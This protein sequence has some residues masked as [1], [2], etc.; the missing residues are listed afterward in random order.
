M[1]ICLDYTTALSLN[2]GDTTTVLDRVACVVYAYLHPNN[3]VV[4]KYICYDNDG[5]LFGP[6][7]LIHDLKTHVFEDCGVR[8]D[9]CLSE[10]KIIFLFH[11]ITL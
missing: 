4:L 1:Y 7:S 3:T 5:W 11:L 9:A 8:P 6:G 2:I 10:Y